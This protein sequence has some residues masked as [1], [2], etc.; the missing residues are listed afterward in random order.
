MQPPDREPRSIRML[1]DV[2]QWIERALFNL[3]AAMLLLLVVV[4]T[5]QVFSRYVMN[6][7]IPWSEEVSRLLLV[8]ATLT[9]AGLASFQGTHLRLDLFSDRLGPRAVIVMAAV[10]AAATL[11]F[12]FVLL[13]GNQDVIEVRDS[14][15]FTSFPSI[16]SKYLSYAISAGCLLM[17][18]GTAVSFV[19]TCFQLNRPKG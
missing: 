13:S 5:L 14:I 16:S 17:M 2:K 8:W 15:P 10:L 19:L 7:S 9:G 12:L 1:L 6:A 3:I 11:Y 18:L 4:V